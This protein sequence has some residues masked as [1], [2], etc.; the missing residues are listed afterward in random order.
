MVIKT[1]AQILSLVWMFG[2]IYYMTMQDILQAILCIGWSISMM[3][4]AIH[5]TLNNN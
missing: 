4:V 1:I 2:S 3:C 5:S